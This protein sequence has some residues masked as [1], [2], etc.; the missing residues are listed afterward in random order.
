M[1]PGS[2]GSA[3]LESGFNRQRKR[4]LSFRRRTDKGEVVK[5]RPEGELGQRGVRAESGCA[6]STPCPANS[7]AVL[8]CTPPPMPPFRC[9]KAAATFS[10]PV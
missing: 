4:K 10:H 1:I 5:G 7:R 9:P 8:Q 3:E 6:G 2:P